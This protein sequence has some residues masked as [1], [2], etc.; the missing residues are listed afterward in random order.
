[1]A[2]T[3]EAVLDMSNLYV[4]APPPLHAPMCA[5]ALRSTNASCAHMVGGRLRDKPVRAHLVDVYR[6]LFLGL[7]CTAVGVYA[8]MTGVVA[9]YLPLLHGAR[10]V[11]MLASLALMGWLMSERAVPSNMG[12]R[13]GI[14]YTFALVQGLSL[15]PLVSLVYD[16]DPALVFTALS[17]AAVLFA[18][19]TAAALL[20]ERRVFLLLG[21]THLSTHTHTHTHMHALTL[22]CPWSM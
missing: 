17:G 22:W 10:F 4:C 18:C 9:A 6:T 2:S 3:L 7:G 16:M 1:M 8:D 13:E 11:T 5:C 12:K 20:A 21:G 15:G 14:F 19:F